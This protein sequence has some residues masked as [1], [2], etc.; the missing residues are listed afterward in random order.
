ML[1]GYT[2]GVNRRGPGATVTDGS[3]RENFGLDTVVDNSSTGGGLKEIIHTVKCVRPCQFPMAPFVGDDYSVTSLH[4]S[5]MY[6]YLHPDTTQQKILSRITL[7]YLALTRRDS[8]SAQCIFNRNTS[9]SSHKHA[10]VWLVP[11]K[12][13]PR[14]S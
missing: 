2:D 4:S 7:L 14:Y 10:T 9:V 3:S 12:P 6:P 13:L 11:A 5:A 1:S 8:A